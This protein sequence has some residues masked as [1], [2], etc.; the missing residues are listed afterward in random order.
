MA[1]KAVSVKHLSKSFVIPHERIDTMRGVVVNMLRKRQ[2]ESFRALDDVSFDVAEGEF[3]GILGRNG[4]GKSTLLRILAGIYE[5][6]AGSVSTTGS[7]SP[8]LE[9][10]IGFNP[11]FSG[12][13]N[14]FLNG[15]ILGMT[16]REIQK[17]YDG[18]VQFSGLSGFM[19]QKVKHYSSGMQVRLAFSVLMH[20]NREILLM[21]EV[22]A[23]G[24]EDF[25]KKCI[26]EFENYRK[27]NRTVILV[28][29][30][31]DAIQKHCGRALFLDHG[32]LIAE[33]K[34]RDVVSLYHSY[35]VSLLHK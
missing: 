6:D 7:V 5:P 23:V 1:P 24:D 8:F 15:I 34:P 28:S 31:L 3:V 27:Q 10:G 22:L 14:I 21:D 2:Y 35:N 30:D 12:R 29:H 4:S 25:Q 11:E 18:I 33:G 9:L 16:R 13:D 17:H 20:A 32:R 19:D 26:Q